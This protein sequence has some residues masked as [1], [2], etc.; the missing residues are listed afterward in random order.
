VVGGG[1]W[2]LE[3]GK[4]KMGW[5]TSDGDLGGVLETRNR[6]GGRD[7]VV[8]D[9][10]GEDGGGEDGGGEDG[11]GEDGGGEDGGGEDGGGDDG[12]V[13]CREGM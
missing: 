3:S 11:G 10:G 2:E 7:G 9:G 13:E 8:A 4:W 5:G 6:V 12:V 1:R